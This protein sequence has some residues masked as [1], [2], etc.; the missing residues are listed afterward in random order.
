MSFARSAGVGMLGSATTMLARTATRR[1]MHRRDGAPRL[2]RAARRPD[3]LTTV[4]V[5]VA[6]GAVLALA[7]V[8]L[9]QRE[10][11]RRA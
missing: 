3:L 9:E 4:L 1:A 2:P 6:A 10:Q 8:L 5:A 11:A 7:D